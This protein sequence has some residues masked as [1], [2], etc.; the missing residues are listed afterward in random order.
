MLVYELNDSNSAKDY[1][2]RR[3]D[4]VSTQ[5][6]EIPECELVLLSPETL[7]MIIVGPGPKAFLSG[8]LLLQLIIR[9]K[10]EC[11]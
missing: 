7:G 4:K 3:V 10:K 9:K 8:G 1:Y 2:S 6:S 5:F 11:T